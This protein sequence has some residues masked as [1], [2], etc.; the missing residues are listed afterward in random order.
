[1]RS[2]CN[3]C[4]N[5]Y[6]NP[7]L[8]IVSP[9]LIAIVAS[10]AVDPV[11]SPSSTT[12]DQDEQS[13]STSPTNQEIQS[14]VT[15]QGPVP[16]FMAPDHSSSGPVLHEMTSDQIRSD[17]TPN[18]QETSVDNISSDL[19]SNKQKASDY[20]ISG[21]V[22]PRKNVVSL[23]DKTDSSQKEIEFLFNHFFE[24]YF[25]WNFYSII[26]L[27]NI[28]LQQM[29]MLKKTTMIKQRMHRFDKM[30]LLILFVHRHEYQWTKDH[31]LEQVI[32]DPTNPVQTRQQLV[33][34]P[35]MSKG[36]AQEDGTDFKESFA[37]VARLEAVR[38]FV[39]HAAHKSFLIYQMDVKTTF[40]NGPLKE[41]VYVAQP[42][43]FVD[44][45]HLE[46]VYLLRKDLYGLK[47]APRAWYN[48]LSNLVMFKGFSKGLQIHQSPKGILINQTKYALEI[49]KK[50]KMDNCHCIGTPLA[51]KPN[52]D[53]YLSGELVDQSDY[54][55]KIGSLMYLTSSI[56][57]LVQAD[58]GFDL[59]AFSD[60]DHAECIDTRKST[61][62]GI[63]FLEHPSDMKVFT[64]KME[65]LLEPTSNKL[66]EPTKPKRKQDDSW[67][68]VKVLLVQAQ[69]HGQILNE[70]ELAFL[71]DPDIPEGQATQTIIT[72]NAAYQANDLDAYDSDC[73]ELNTAKV[74]LM[75]NLSHYGS[76][77]F[78]EVH[79]HDNVNNN[80]INQA[81]QVMPSFEQSNVMKHSETEITS[82]SNIIPFSQYVIESQQAVVQNSNSSAQKDALILSVIEQLKTQVVNCI[83]IHLENKSVND[84]LI[85]ELERYK[86]QVKVLKEGQNVDLKKKESLMQTVTLLKNDFKK[87]E[88]RNIYREIALEKRI[89][90]L[91]NI[92]FKRD[93]F[94]QTVHMLTKP[95]FFYDHTTKQAL[96]FQNP[97]YL[98]KAQQLE[99]KL[100][101]EPTL[102]ISPTNV[103]V[104]KELPKVSMVNMSLN[105]LKHHL[106]NFDVDKV[107]KDIEETETINI[108]L[109]HRV[110]KLIAENEHL[111]QTYKQLYDSIKPARIRSKEQCEDLIN[112]VNLKSVEISNLNA[113][114]QEKVLV[115]I[116]LKDDLRKFKGK[117]LVNND[118]TKHTIDPEMLKIDLEY[119]NP[120]LLNNRS[121]H[122]DY[123]KHTQEEAAI[124]RE[125][126]EQGK[127]QNPLNESLESACKY[128]KQIQELLIIIG[129][130]CPSFNEKLVAV[131]P[132]NKDKR[133]RFTEPVTF[134]GNTITKSSSTSNLV[135][136]KPVLSSI[137]VKTSTS[138]SRSQPSGNTKKDKIL[139]TPRTAHV[140]HSKL[141][142]NSKLK[143]VKC[144]GCMLFDN[145]D[146]CVLDFINNV[147][148]RAKS[149]SV[150]KSSK[151]KVWKPKG[152]MITTTT[153]V[154]L[155]KPTALDNET[156]KPV[157][158]L[159][160]SRKPRKSKTNVPVSK[161]KVLKSVS[162]NK[163]EP[164]KSLGSIVSDIHLPTYGMQASK[165]KSW[166]WHRR[167]SHLN[168][169]AINHLARHGLV[170]GLP[171]LKFEKDNICSACA[172]GKS[173]KK[174]HKP[175][176]EDTN[177]EKLY[178]FHMY[179]CG[180][181]HVAS[182]NG[183]KYILV[184]IDDYS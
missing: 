173:K 52:L 100:Y 64:V 139:Q 27:K 42:E 88:S 4:L 135:S 49:L 30:N 152:K 112:Q 104:P 130:T 95:Q 82:D 174:P 61:S 136:N 19:V 165:T 66:M 151:R 86:E 80:M 109:D 78:A 84:T 147:N 63:Q 145:H 44:A 163:K 48:E 108:E 153:K 2:C 132:K 68:K 79:N 93:Q 170:R 122:S 8:R 28:S 69:A 46:K 183:K 119:L 98:K 181:M 47:Q 17:L 120:R 50:H 168:F 142:A 169:G 123:L 178:L 41:E 157:V 182:I 54:H 35:E 87:E 180:P 37:P 15:H 33:T 124:L 43:G 59:T 99:P 131:P 137:G 77:A 3:H 127:S 118:V 164:N 53:V 141:N 75:A 71:V 76:D 6:Y 83:K 90:Q 144:N 101:D 39:A 85:A 106:A 125:I 67:F 56:P 65:I 81:V 115:I 103:E 134:L 161:S 32:G 45:E 31:P 121:A 13:T 158:T 34:D 126:V 105:K 128:T 21:P 111:K 175:K 107:N 7:L 14:Q 97:F 179:L 74:S 5:E 116:A 25:S 57:D 70:E 177:Q 36:Y 10:R 143:C 38:I 176:S 89:K 166:L 24:E 149:K 72:H 102:S 96:G 58:Y 184:I 26:S 148:A 162:A 110:S 51:T 91:D 171:K 11:G 1:M 22:P 40:L 154:P 20:D 150:K 172:M 156:S 16:Q 92:V 55:S 129:Q 18:R 9:D 117:A 159:V 167:L 62:G 12:I 114:L 140:Q 29:F 160:Y 138:D 94:A 146:L 113:R 73:D 155:R 60:V 23:A 133:V